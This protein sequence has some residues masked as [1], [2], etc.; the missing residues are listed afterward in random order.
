MTCR[1]YADENFAGAAVLALRALGHDVLTARENG[2]A[3]LGI[4]DEQVLEFAT[5]T[6]RALLT[7]NRK[8]FLRLHRHDPHH[9]GIVICTLT[10]DHLSLARRIHDATADLDTLAGHLIR[11]Y[12]PA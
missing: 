1:F 10:A 7:F 2:Q 3:D 4:P 6:Q 8:H 5:T 12:R 11:I 9:G